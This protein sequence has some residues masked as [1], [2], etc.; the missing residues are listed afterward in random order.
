[1]MFG[2]FE[3]GLNEVPYCKSLLPSLLCSK[4]FVMKESKSQVPPGCPTNACELKI[5]DDRFVCDVKE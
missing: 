5:A 3:E 4:L 1:M 2:L